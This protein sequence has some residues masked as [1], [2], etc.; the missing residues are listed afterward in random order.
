MEV[1]AK[2]RHGEA[3]PAASKA[4]RAIG[5]DAPALVVG[6][7]Q[8]GLSCVR[9]LAAREIPLAVIDSRDDPPALA[10]MRAEFPEISLYLGGFAAR[11]FADASTLVVSPGVSLREP[12]IETAIAAGKPVLG[13]IELF[14]RVVTAPVIAIT[15]SNGK[16]T[17]TSLV[18]EMARRAGRVVG[19]GGNLG[20]PALSLLTNG[21]ADLYV[22]EVSS[23][24]LEATSSLRAAAAVVLNVS[25]DHM[26]RY[27][28]LDAYINAKRRVYRGDGVMV[29]NL[30]DRHVAAMREADRATVGFTLEAPGSGDLGIRR[31]A[32]GE[33][34][35]HGEEPLLPVRELRISGRHNT[36]NALA[37]LALGSAIG[38]ERK[39]MCE[40]LREFEGLA[41]RCQLIAS[42][43]GVRWFNDSKA[44]N[45]GATV[46]AIEGLSGERTLIWIGGGLGKGADFSP[47]HNV[48]HERVR[49]AILIGRD[50]DRIEAA[51]GSAVP[52]ERAASMGE[53]VARARELARPGESVL[54][55]PACASFDMYENYAARGEHFMTLVR[56]GAR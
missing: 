52:V 34:L 42:S 56:E 47:L 14:A 21:E 3:T 45:V 35:C 25:A 17:V 23:F 38:L 46:A 30:D 11:P 26:D 27:P 9:F 20:P 28:S 44:T 39:S 29:L 6:L 37:A 43:A 22:L 8:T 5:V 55:S 15:G 49:V 53:A 19:I 10:T 32:D 13:D 2:S 1:S 36:A 4:A 48:V 12:P 40:T 7:G 54:L 33:W 41:H 16:S 50:A 24:Q 18:G 51:V 31:Q